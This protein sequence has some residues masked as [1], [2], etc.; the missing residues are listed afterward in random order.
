L[1]SPATGFVFKKSSTFVVVACKK[2]MKL[3]KTIGEVEKKHAWN[4]EGSPEAARRHRLAS[5]DLAFCNGSCQAAVVVVVVVV[6]FIVVGKVDF[7][8]LHHQKVHYFKCWVHGVVYCESAFFI[9]RN[10]LDQCSN[11]IEPRKV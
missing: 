10:F 7:N 3:E 6:V 11:A 5:G 1:H 4:F 9:V 8:F 2:Q